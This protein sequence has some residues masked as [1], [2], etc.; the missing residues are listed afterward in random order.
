MMASAV[1]SWKVCALCDTEASARRSGGVGMR[2]KL[3]PLSERAVLDVAL[4][5]GAGN[6]ASFSLSPVRFEFLCR[7]AEGALPGSFSNESMTHSGTSR[8]SACATRSGAA[9]CGAN[10]GRLPRSC[11]ISSPSRPVR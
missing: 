7:V 5:F 4:A 10:D 11:A 1:W 6:S 3:D 9:Q 8:L 2:I